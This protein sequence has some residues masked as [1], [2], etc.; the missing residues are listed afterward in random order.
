MSS[1]I[2]SF[3]DVPDKMFASAASEPFMRPQDFVIHDIGSED[4]SLEDLAGMAM[5]FLNDEEFPLESAVIFRAGVDRPLARAQAFV[6]AYP[7]LLKRGKPF[8]GTGKL[9]D[10]IIPAIDTMR[11]TRARMLAAGIVFS[12]ED[13]SRHTTRLVAA[14]RLTELCAELDDESAEAI[15][16]APEISDTYD[17]GEKTA[18]LVGSL[19]LLDPEQ[20]SETSHQYPAIAGFFDLTPEQRA[21]ELHVEKI[22]SIADRN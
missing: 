13:G 16:N 9:S 20:V 3:F 21:R 4:P 2:H 8:R 5:A 15:R 1:E 18:L 6:D 7:E 14:R 19:F 10:L 17:L 12:S 22:K 11:S